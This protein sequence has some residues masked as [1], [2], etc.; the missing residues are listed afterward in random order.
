M[1]KISYS[2]YRGSAAVYLQKKGFSLDDVRLAGIDFEE[3]IRKAYDSGMGSYLAAQSIVNRLTVAA[4][5]RDDFITQLK[6]EKKMETQFRSGATSVEVVNQRTGEVSVESFDSASLADAVAAVSSGN[7]VPVARI[8]SELVKLEIGDSIEGVFAGIVKLDGQWGE[9][10]A[11]RLL[12]KRNGVVGFVLV[13]GVQLVGQVKTMRLVENKT[14]IKI[15]AVEHQ[16]SHNGTY[17][18]YAVYLLARRG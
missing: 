6:G 11:V 17:T 3:E 4:D 15:E 9:F 18:V 2:G 14:A 12:A 5:K 8:D 13:A 1:I 10:E 16:K 7:F